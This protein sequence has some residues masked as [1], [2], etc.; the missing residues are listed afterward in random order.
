MQE[1]IRRWFRIRRRGEFL[2]DVSSRVLYLSRKDYERWQVDRSLVYLFI[3]SFISSALWRYARDTRWQLI[4]WN[5]RPIRENPW[6]SFTYPAEIRHI[7]YQIEYWYRRA[8]CHIIDNNNS[9][10]S[11]EGWRFTVANCCEIT[12]FWSFRRSL[13]NPRFFVLGMPRS[14]D[15]KLRA[16]TYYNKTWHITIFHGKNVSLW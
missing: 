1:E 11:A 6:L 7:R 5:N 3:F 9:D 2:D 16:V 8:K 10:G 15:S 13:R 4:P 14:I 12:T